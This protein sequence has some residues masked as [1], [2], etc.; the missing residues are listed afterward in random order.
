MYRSGELSGQELWEQAVGTNM[1]V[2]AMNGERIEFRLVQAE[3][4]VPLD[5][6]VD[7]VWDEV[8]SL[9]HTYG[10]RG[11]LRDAARI[12]VEEGGTVNP[13]YDY[14]DG[15]VMIHIPCVRGG[16]GAAFANALV[17]G[18]CDGLGRWKLFGFGRLEQKGDVLLSAS[19][20]PS[21]RRFV[22]ERIARIDRRG[23]ASGHL[24]ETRMRPGMNNMTRY[25]S[26][27]EEEGNDFLNG[28][29][30]RASPPGTRNSTRQGGNRGSY[31]RNRLGA[32]GQ[33]TSL[34]DKNPEARSH[35]G[36]QRQ[37]NRRRETV[38]G[39]LRGTASA[40]PG[41]C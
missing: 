2:V 9:R 35:R 7:R 24:Q 4:H 25:T 27:D 37:A 34:R 6:F 18:E 3:N 41:W 40:H 16:L 1:S 5:S 21:E 36:E 31:G 38:N 10:I 30:R 14:E 13:I 17:Q 22:M 33:Q 11:T 19:V 8:D 15:E 39:R 32:R 23:T 26:E 12:C 29:G 20:S 28:R